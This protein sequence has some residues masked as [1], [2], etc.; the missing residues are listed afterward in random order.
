M[1]P[2]GDMKG[3]D[4]GIVMAQLLLAQAVNLLAVVDVLCD[5]GAVGDGFEDLGH[6]GVGVGAEERHPAAGVP[7]EDDADEAAGHGVGGQKGLVGF[8]DGFAIQNEGV[9][10][11]TLGV[12]GAFGQGNRVLAVLGVGAAPFRCVG[13]FGVGGAAQRRVFAEAGDD[14]ETELG[15]CL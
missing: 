5:G 7:D 6:G 8:G 11:P 3:G 9:G 12:A 14:G 10:P 1:Q 15:G 13:A 4:V 2:S